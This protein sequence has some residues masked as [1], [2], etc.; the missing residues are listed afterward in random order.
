MNRHQLIVGLRRLNAVQQTAKRSS[1]E[2]L[3]RNSLHRRLRLCRRPATDRLR[4]ISTSTSLTARRAERQCR[5]VL[6]TVSV[7][8]IGLK[9]VQQRAQYP[10]FKAPPRNSL[11]QRLRLYWRLGGRAAGALRYG[12][13]RRNE[14]FQLGGR[15]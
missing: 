11:Y 6:R 13:E 3:L 12:A 2:A 1:S 4:G 10:S 15:S 14:L 5:S 7:P 9:P 8:S